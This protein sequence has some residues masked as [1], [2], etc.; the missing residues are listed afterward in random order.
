HNQNADFGAIILDNTSFLV[1][2]DMDF[3]GLSDDV[4]NQVYYT[5]PANPDSDNDGYGDGEEIRFGGNPLDLLNFPTDTVSPS[6]SVIGLV[7]ETVNKRIF[8]LNVSSS[9]NRG[10]NYTD[11]WLNNSQIYFR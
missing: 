1:G 2:D 11:I 10:I 6:L 3:D 7:N 5:D 4:E 8:S 9:D